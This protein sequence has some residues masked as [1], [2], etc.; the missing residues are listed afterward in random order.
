MDCLVHPPLETAVLDPQGTFQGQLS[1]KII[2]KSYVQLSQ[3]P[4][5]ESNKLLKAEHAALGMQWRKRTTLLHQEL[6]WGKTQPSTTNRFPVAEQSSM[7]SGKNLTK[8]CCCD[9]STGPGAHDGASCGERLNKSSVLLCWAW[10]NTWSSATETLGAGCQTIRLL[11]LWQ[12]P[13]PESKLLKGNGMDPFQGHR[14]GSSPARTRVCRSSAGRRSRELLSSAQGP[15]GQRAR[16]CSRKA[17][18]RS[19]LPSFSAD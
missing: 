18:P 3:I 12:R 19:P 4:W 13:T 2:V 15:G 17:E 6:K 10:H 16:A 7:F 9:P 8:T 5:M 14:S 11:Q 1:F